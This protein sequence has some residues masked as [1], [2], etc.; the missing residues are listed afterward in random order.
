M[1]ALHGR[2]ARIW[3]VPIPQRKGKTAATNLKP[4]DQAWFHHAGHV[5]HVATVMAVFH[6]LEFDRALWPVSAFP[7]SGFIF[8]LAKPQAARMAKAAV[9]IRLG[10]LPGFTWQGNLLLTEEKSSTLGD[11]VEL[12]L[13]D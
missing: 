8:T 13:A 1:G 11:A 2:F 7:H 6:N 4:C 3:G 12:T 9:N 10:Y 5:H